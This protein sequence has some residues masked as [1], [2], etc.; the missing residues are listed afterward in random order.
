[1]NIKLILIV[2]IAFLYGFFEVF[3]HLRQRRKGKVVTQSDKGSLSL[4]YI[5]ITTG[6]FLSFSIGST[7]TGRIY[8]WNS[9]FAIGMILVVVGFVIRIKAIMT[10][11][12]YFTYSV[13][14]VEDHKLIERGLYKRIRHPAYLGQMLIY[15]GISTSLSNWLSILFMMIPISIGYIYR[16]RIE[17][18]F[19]IEQ[20]GEDYLRY[21]NQTKRLIPMIF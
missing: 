15:I 21:Q 17:E 6:Y 1:M 19:M 2:V 9:L 8:H 13:T 12:Q 3:M 14:Q 20:L 16:I 18:R 10:L 11:K 4:L 7:K 5:L